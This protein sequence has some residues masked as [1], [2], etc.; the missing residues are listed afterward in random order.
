M[1]QNRANICKKR[2]PRHNG[3]S[4]QRR[5]DMFDQVIPR[6]STGDEQAMSGNTDEVI[7]LVLQAQK[8]DESAFEELYNM[9]AK[10]L[11][12]Y[13]ASRIPEEHA[14]DLVSEIFFRVWKKIPAFQG[15]AQGQFRAWMF[16]IAHHL[17]IDFY[18]ANKETLPLEEGVEIAD[19]DTFH[20]PTHL[21]ATETDFDRTQEALTKLPEK[22]RE[23]LI[24]RYMNDISLPDI[25]EIMQ[26]KEGNVRILIHRAL[27]RL[28]ELLDT[29]S[30][31]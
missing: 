10:D 22:Q 20:D 11:Y 6:M 16:T 1:R 7:A 25:A 15:H 23:A 4:Y 24:L 26:E 21:L 30:L 2:L 14:S 29:D 28:R 18:R 31:D 8:G 9:F 17:V 5:R 3:T 19:E 12:R 27:K 13:T